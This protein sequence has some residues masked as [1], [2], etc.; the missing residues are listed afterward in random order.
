VLK[1]GHVYFTS[2][3]L[4]VVV[5]AAAAAAAPCAVPSGTVTFRRQVLRDTPDWSTSTKPLKSCRVQTKGLIEDSDSRCHADFANQFIG[6]GVLSG[7]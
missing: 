6:G 3:I 1:K 4:I 5:V 7:V 2:L